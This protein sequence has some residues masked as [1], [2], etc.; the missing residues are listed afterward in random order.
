MLRSQRW[1]AQR[2]FLAFAI[3]VVMTTTSA[4][5]QKWA[6]AAALAALTVFAGLMGAWRWRHTGGA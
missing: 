3:G 6:P 2:W 1:I 5:Q 4:V